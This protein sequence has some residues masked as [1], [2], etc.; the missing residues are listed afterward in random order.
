VR[1]LRV[2]KHPIF[3]RSPPG[4]ALIYVKNHRRQPSEHST[5]YA[6][7]SGYCLNPEWLHAPTRVAAEFRLRG[8]VVDVLLQYL[9]GA[10]HPSHALEDG[11][12]WPRGQQRDLSKQETKSRESNTLRLKLIHDRG[13]YD[14]CSSTKRTTIRRTQMTGISTSQRSG[15]KYETKVDR[16]LYVG[17]NLD[18]ARDLFVKVIKHRPKI[19]LAIR[20]RTR[21][22]DQ[23][24]ARFPA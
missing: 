10:S 18:T 17:K 15:R 24:S 22:L 14:R 7:V 21:V 1:A 9:V 12:D 11:P 20:Q 16:L 8:M 23:R 2:A 3:F 5:A 19:R 13:T 6:I 4:Q